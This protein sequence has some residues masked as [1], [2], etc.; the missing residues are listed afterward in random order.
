MSEQAVEN[1]AMVALLQKR[2][3]LA[4]IRIRVGLAFFWRLPLAA[5]ERPAGA[6]ILEQR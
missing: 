4:Y 5:F 1:S 6:L 2:Q 3:T